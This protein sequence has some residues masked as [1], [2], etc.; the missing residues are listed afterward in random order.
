V[1]SEDVRIEKQ[2][3]ETGVAEIFSLLVSNCI[4]GKQNLVSFPVIGFNLDE[5]KLGAW[6]GERESGGESTKR[7]YILEGGGAKSSCFKGSGQ[8]PFVLLVNVCWREGKALES[9]ENKTLAS[10]LSHE[11][12][13]EVDRGPIG[14]SVKKLLL[15]FASRVVP[16]FILLEINDLRFLFSP[17]HARVLEVGP[18]LRRLRGR[19]LYVGATFLAPQLQ[20][21]S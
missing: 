9:V 21:F 17:R 19:S 14:L 5:F 13:G 1:G 16:G 8:C 15:V 4:I 11:Q 7:R 10:G 6:G 12:M 3:P 18:P 2:A 20:R